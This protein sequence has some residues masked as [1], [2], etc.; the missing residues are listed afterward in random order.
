[1]AKS[2][3]RARKQNAGRARTTRRRNPAVK[4]FR[5]RRHN[6]GMTGGIFT[7]A[8]G[9]TAGA[10]GSKI[11]AQAVLGTKNTGVMGYAGNAAAGGFLAWAAHAFLKKL[12][13]TQSILVG[14]AVQ[15]FLRVIGDYSLIGSYSAQIGVGDYMVSNWVSPQRL[16]DPKSAMVQIPQGW[17]PTTIVRSSSGVNAQALG[18]EPSRG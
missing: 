13:V 10:L 15:I 8:L 5:R 17:V 9:V 2:S 3:K 7:M 4:M 16:P 11:G 14:T 1:M 18:L 12:V 6:P